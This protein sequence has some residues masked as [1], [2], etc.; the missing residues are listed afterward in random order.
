MQQTILQYVQM[1]ARQKVLSYDLIESLGS[2]FFLE[3]IFLDPI[4]LKI[5]I[6][7]VGYVVESINKEEP[8]LLN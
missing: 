6:I 5:F 1:R 4:L 8:N 3:E 2:W 7:D